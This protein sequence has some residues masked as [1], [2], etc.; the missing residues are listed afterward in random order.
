[1]PFGLTIAPGTFQAF[2]NDIFRDLLDIKVLVYL[3]D[4]LVFTEEG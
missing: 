2:I 1:M 4:I 3:D